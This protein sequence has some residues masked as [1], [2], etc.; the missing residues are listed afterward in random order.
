MVAS[1]TLRAEKRPKEKTYETHCDHVVGNSTGFRPVIWCSGA[2]QQRAGYVVRPERSS[3]QKTSEE[4]QESFQDDLE[5]GSGC[6]PYACQEMMVWF[7]TKGAAE[8]P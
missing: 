4:A 5:R 6:C 1:H 7:G 2:D 3:C 8:A